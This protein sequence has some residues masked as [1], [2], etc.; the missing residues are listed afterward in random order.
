MNNECKI[1]VYITT[2]NRPKLLARALSSLS[3]QSYSNFEVIVCNDF[4]D[5]KFEEEYNNIIEGFKEE[6]KDLVYLCNNERMGACF[7]RNRAINASRG[8]YITGLDDDDVFDPLRL[9]MFMTSP[10]LHQYSFL[11]SGVKKIASREMLLKS[12]D[13]D[14]NVIDFEQ[15][16]N[17]NVVG[18][19]VFIRTELLKKLGGF[20]IRLPAWQ[21]YDMW[22][23][24][25][26]AFGPGFKINACTMYL[27][28][29]RG[30]ER[31]TTGSKAYEGYKMFIAKHGPHLSEKNM[32]ALRYA[33][34]LNR[35]QTISLFNELL[36]KDR[37]LYIKVNKYQMVYK[38]KW[39]YSIYQRYIK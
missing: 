31:I 4:S 6:I 30:R 36:F 26:E 34:L 32:T 22:F 33:D 27:D 38:C 18:N 5:S 12:I 24:V 2:L 17:M 15:M 8:E 3:S 13:Y 25:I 28:D 21:D 1:T 16:K 23:R 19:Q 11:C 14:G 20:D 39:L 29:D 9:E 10:D 35:K 37:A 7:S